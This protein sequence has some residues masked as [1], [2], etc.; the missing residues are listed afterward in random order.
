M[1]K[2]D[3]EK[4]LFLTNQGLYYY[5]VMPFGMKN[6]GPTFQRL[7]NKVFKPLISKTMEVYVNDTITKSF[8]D[9]DHDQH[10]GETFSLLKKFNMVLHPKK[11][12]FR[13]KSGKFLAFMVSERGIEANP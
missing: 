5:K 8:R 1:H 11:C 12:A 13:V 9:E 4:T 7:V 3:K 6:V 2:D 10:L